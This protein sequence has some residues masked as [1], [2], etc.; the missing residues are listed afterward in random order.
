MCLPLSWGTYNAFRVINILFH[1][2]QAG[3]SGFYF[4]R[5][6]PSSPLYT[7]DLSL[8]RQYLEKVGKQLFVY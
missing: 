6:T 1:M 8:L 7:N 4:H 5:R 3:Q 2:S